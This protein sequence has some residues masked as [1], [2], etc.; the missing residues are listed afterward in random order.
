MS[1]NTESE[2]RSLSASELEMV[3]GTQSPAIEQQSK[4][5]L[6]ALLHRLRQAHSRANDI[7]AR[8]QRELRGKADPHGVK[9]VQDNSGSVAKAQSLFEAIQRVDRELSRREEIDT[10][11]PSSGEFARHA[12]EL[13]MSSETNQ[14]PD[15]GRTASKG[16][17]SKK[18]V[19]D[20]AVGTT[21]R[22]IGR[23]SQAG[24]AAQARKDSG[25]T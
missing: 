5:Q 19:E 6:K 15:P 14:H 8:Q 18:R 12:L 1:T 13:K 4:E 21:R 10:G 9:R 7:S 3:S 17:R 23:V 20:F 16:M 24:K 2:N 11:R 25:K 22:E